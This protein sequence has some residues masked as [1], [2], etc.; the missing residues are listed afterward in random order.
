VAVAVVIAS[1]GTAATAAAAAAAAA[2]SQRSIRSSA[3]NSGSSSSSDSKL[4]A[5]LSAQ[6]AELAHTLRL[7][8]S[9][10]A[11]VGEALVQC[12]CYAWLPFLRTAALLLHTCNGDENEVRCYYHMSHPY[13]LTAVAYWS[14]S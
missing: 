2:A 4:T 1:T 11:P 12:V 3:N 8:V 9:Q 13:T 6:R 7:P 5:A 10:Q 14:S